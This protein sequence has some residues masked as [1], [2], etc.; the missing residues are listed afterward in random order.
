MDRRQYNFYLPEPSP[1]IEHDK[2]RDEDGTNWGFQHLRQFDIR[3]QN[4][5]RLDDFQPWFCNEFWADAMIGE[6]ND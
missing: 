5:A 3:D 1:V 6:D 4:I 2:W